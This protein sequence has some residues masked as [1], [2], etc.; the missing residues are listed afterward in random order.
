MDL[1]S[2]EAVSTVWHSAARP[3]LMSMT[4]A[5]V[6]SATFLD[7]IEAAGTV[8]I[9]TQRRQQARDTSLCRAGMPKQQQAL[10]GGCA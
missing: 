3:T 1:A 7:T 8:D 4:S 6:P 10:L 2:V 5:R 9:V